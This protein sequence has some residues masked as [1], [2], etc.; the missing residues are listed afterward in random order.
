MR[1]RKKK[2]AKLELLQGNP[3]K[4]PVNKN[5]PKPAERAPSCPSHLDTQAKRIWGKVVKQ[6]L[7]LG[8]VTEIDEAILALYC[9]TYST[10]LTLTQE[11]KRDG[12][13]IN[14]PVRERTGELVKD[15][16]GNVITEP[17]KNPRVVEIRLH[18]AQ[19]KSLAAE[20]GLTATSRARI[21]VPMDGDEEDEMKEFMAGK[22]ASAS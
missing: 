21:Q 1:G 14:I 3:G 17:I 11:L 5:E 7:P 20:I 13:F 8:L 9:Q 6:L 10:W 22:T 19:L 15:F 16:N 2:P 4:R 12:A 18:T